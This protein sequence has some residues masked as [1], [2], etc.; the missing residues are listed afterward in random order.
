MALRSNFSNTLIGEKQKNN[1]II[2]IQEDIEKIITNYKKYVFIGDSYGDGYNP[3]G[4]TTSWI[5]LLVNKLNLEG[6]CNI[7]KD[8]R[9]ENVFFV[10]YRI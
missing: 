3:D 8:N 5:S 10:F 2:N 4:N 7:S 1:D 9:H 6:K